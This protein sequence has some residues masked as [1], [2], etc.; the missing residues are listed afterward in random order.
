M[1]VTQVMPQAVPFTDF[2]PIPKGTKM[3]PR[4][5]ANLTDG[6]KVKFSRGDE[7]DEEWLASGWSVD[8]ARPANEHDAGHLRLADPAEMPISLE[9][10][11]FDVERNE[12]NDSPAGFKSTIMVRD[13]VGNSAVGSCSMN[14]PMNFPD[15]FWRRWT[16]LTYKDF[17]G[18]LEP[19]QPPPEFGADTARPRLAL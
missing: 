19:G 18:L 6:I 2:K 17:A 8:T 5:R 11:Q 10:K 7:H 13:A 14:E 16:G 12:G 3:A 15:T 4:D 1:E 9:L